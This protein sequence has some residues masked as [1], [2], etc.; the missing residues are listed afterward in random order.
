MIVKCNG[1]IKNYWQQLLVCTE[2]MVHVMRSACLLSAH[3]VDH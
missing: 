3:I 1:G 2:F